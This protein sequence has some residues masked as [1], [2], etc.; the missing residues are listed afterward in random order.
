MDPTWYPTLVTAGWRQYRDGRLDQGL[1]QWN[2]AG[3]DGARYV[4][5]AE[6][7]GAS[8]ATASVVRLG[9]VRIAGDLHGGV[10]HT[11]RARIP[12]PMTHAASRGPTT[13][14][15]SANRPASIGA[16]PANQISAAAGWQLGLDRERY[17]QRAGGK[18]EQSQSGVVR[19][20][21]RI[22]EE[23]RD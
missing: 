23:E 2:K 7:T 10:I 3:R 18:L 5:P 9:H 15:S 22:E 6:F 20:Q 1:A 17:Q 14:A 19:R 11:S 21:G 16:T 12:N 8:L 4:E 13:N